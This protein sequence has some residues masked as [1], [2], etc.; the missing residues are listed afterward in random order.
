MVTL[1]SKWSSLLLR[2]M[3]LCVCGYSA[4]RNDC[5]LSHLSI[6][7]VAVCHQLALIF[8]W[9]LF[10]FA[11]DVFA[12]TQIK[13]VVIARIVS[14][15]HWKCAN[16]W[17]L[18]FFFSSWCSQTDKQLTH[19]P[20]TG[21]RWQRNNTR[22]RFNWTT[23]HTMATDELMQMTQI[24]FCLRRLA[25]HWSVRNGI[26]WKLKSRASIEPNENWSRQFCVSSIKVNRIVAK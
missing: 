11:G 4:I 3:C 22:L 1:T 6:C 25:K 19:C 16:K 8:R 14:K 13:H 9:S 24:P 26:E 23:R 2:R 15:C 10:I 17:F 12:S 5:A 7:R 20:F 21:R 18:P